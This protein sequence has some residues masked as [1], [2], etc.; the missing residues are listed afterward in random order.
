LGELCGGWQEVSMMISNFANAT[1]AC[2]VSE[3]DAD[4]SLDHR[5]VFNVL[6]RLIDR[7][8]IKTAWVRPLWKELLSSLRASSG[9]MNGPQSVRFLSELRSSLTKKILPH[10]SRVSSAIS[11]ELHKLSL[12]KTERFIADNPT[13]TITSSFLG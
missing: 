4:F 11:I 10:A 12:L 2:I 8:E 1:D 7:P 5:G 13:I 3:E 6:T 9:H